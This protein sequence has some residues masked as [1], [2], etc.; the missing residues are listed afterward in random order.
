MSRP[1]TQPAAPRVLLH[2]QHL[3]GIGHVR[4]AAAI[5][6]AMT[7]AGL[8]VTVASGGGAVAGVDFGAAELAE[9]P[10]ARAADSSFSA[11]VDAAGRPVDEAWWQARTAA[12][13]A[14]FRAR[15]PDVLLI[16]LFPFGRR[17]FGRE[18]LP[19]LEAAATASPRPVVLCSLR[20]ILVDKGRSAPGRPDRIAET[21][22]LVRRH[23]DRVLVHGDPRLAG[24]EL[25]FPGA[26]A[27]ADRIAY[28]GYVVE[29]DQGPESRGGP[30]GEGDGAGDVLVSAGGGAVGG[31]LLRA[32]LAARPLSRMGGH[33]W[34]L[35]TGPNLPAAELAAIR[36]AAGPDV[37]VESF[38]PDLARLFGRCAVSLSQ[39]GYNTVMEL[40]AARA[41]AVV[42]PFASA[43]E[44]EQ[45]ARARLLAARGLL[46]L[47][48]G[49]A[50]P[51]RLAAAIDEAAAR[52]RP[53]PAAIDLD[54][55]AATARLVRSLVPA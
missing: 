40:I 7:R 20:D 18:L 55:A 16:E 21:V 33:S 34:R 53:E 1:P 38:R 6:R 37:A 12:L 17:A 29:Q 32:S 24:L 23:F 30:D 27:I 51:E 3:L 11:I 22:A 36:A 25:S 35:V 47:V 13:L 10:A 15:R 39:G 48:E 43:G 2:V 9:L 14:L 42:V 4:R 19:L 5:A 46:T 45:A 44:T 52:P 8:A 28:T 26:T 50:T 49:P 54:G 31:E 41:R